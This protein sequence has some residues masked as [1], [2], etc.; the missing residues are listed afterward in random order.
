MFAGREL[1]WFGCRTMLL[2]LVTQYSRSL[3]CN[4]TVQA[5]SRC[6]ALFETTPCCVSVVECVVQSTELQCNRTVAPPSPT[7]DGDMTCPRSEDAHQLTTQVIGTDRQC[8][9]GNPGRDEDQVL[10]GF[11][12]AHHPP[13]MLFGIEMVAASGSKCRQDDPMKRF[14]Q[15]FG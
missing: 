10:F 2:E 13:Q 8:H 5:S 9:V 14:I 3:R 1:D 4:D 15:H 11:E 7:I 6:F 12:L